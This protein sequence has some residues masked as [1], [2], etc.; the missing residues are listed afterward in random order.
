M[1]I[2]IK[3]V[4]DILSDQEELNPINF[5]LNYIPEAE[6]LLEKLPVGRLVEIDTT[7]TDYASNDPLSLEFCV[8]VDLW[9]SSLQEANKYY[10][11]IDKLMRKNNW[12]C[13]YSE[14]TTDVDLEKCP[15]I[16]KRYYTIQRIK[17]N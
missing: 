8:Q 11:L 12:Q 17:I 5:Y 4:F 13:A 3:Q 10:F 7:Y 15:R 16:I 6:Q 2:P 1:N 14:L 9:F